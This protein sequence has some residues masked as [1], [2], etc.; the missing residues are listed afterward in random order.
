MPCQSRLNDFHSHLSQDDQDDYFRVAQNSTF[1]AQDR[2]KIIRKPS[3]EAARDIQ[4]NFLDLV[5]IDADHS[6]EGCKADIEAYY[7]KVK[8]GGIISGHDYANNAWKFGPLVKKAVDE[9][10]ASK[11]LTL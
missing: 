11:A 5:F 10:V 7:G 6:Y 8:P 3:N 9:F 4:D 1:F 2:A